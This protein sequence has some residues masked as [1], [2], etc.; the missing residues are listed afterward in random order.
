MHP[1]DTL[2][3]PPHCRP[4]PRHDLASHVTHAAASQECD[5]LLQ[6][7]FPSHQPL[8]S[9]V[10]CCEMCDAVEL[11]G[12]EDVI[13]ITCCCTVESICSKECREI[14]NNLTRDGVIIIV[15]D[16]P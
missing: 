5:I 6:H 12:I 9:S 1:L 14:V 8:Y 10:T 11:V 13:A 15:Y 2:P 4:R 3:P 16:S 7:P